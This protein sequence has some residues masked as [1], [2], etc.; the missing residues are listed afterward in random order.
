M[1]GGTKKSVTILC[2]IKVYEIEMFF[3]SEK[4]MKPKLY[5]TV[6]ELSG[7]NINIIEVFIS[8]LQMKSFS[9]KTSVRMKVSALKTQV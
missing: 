9:T 5:S 7:K 8:F 2:T 6:F 1:E 4:L 3:N